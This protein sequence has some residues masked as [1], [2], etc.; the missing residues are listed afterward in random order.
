M[1]AVCSPH[2][3]HLTRDLVSPHLLAVEQVASRVTSC[4]TSRVTSNVTSNVT[5]VG[6]AGEAAEEVGP[7][8]GA[9]GDHG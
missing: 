9:R 6:E 2:R 3:A 5:Y 1:E 8:G 7:S 4:V